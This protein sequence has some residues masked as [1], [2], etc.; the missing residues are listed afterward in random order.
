LTMTVRVTYRPATAAAVSKT[1]RLTLTL[2]R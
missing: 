2:T 1:A